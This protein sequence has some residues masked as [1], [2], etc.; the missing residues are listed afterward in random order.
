MK[1]KGK[2]PL[3]PTRQPGSGLSREGE[4]GEEKN[5]PG[6]ASGLPAG[7]PPLSDVDRKLLAQRDKALKPYAD[8]LPYDRD[9]VIT[10][11]KFLMRHEVIAK[12]EIGKRLI[13][14]REQEGVRTCGQ[15][16]EEHFPGMS[17]QR[18]YEY[19]LFARK[20]ANLPKV[21]DFAEGNGNWKKCLALLES[22][23]E[24]ELAALE[25]GESVAGKTLDDV[26]KMSFR[27]LKA[28]MRK[29]EE[30]I[31]KIKTDSA[32]TIFELE[33]K[34]RELEDENKSFKSGIKTPDD[35]WQQYKRADKQI[36][37]AAMIIKRLPEHIIVEDIVLRA[38][39]S[40]ALFVIET[41]VQN[42]IRN[43]AK[44][45]ESE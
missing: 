21:R 43:I 41:M 20:V 15:I 19:M 18:A 33:D 7:T 44:I 30:K 11:T 12:Y 2:S 26:D 45:D 1:D 22:F 14:L 32:M 27:E 38:K 13:L 6:P 23:D 40:G 24:E 29:G 42:I 37:D 9:R 10:E 35:Y 31:N 17:R 5:M 39:V 34:N 36:T 25:A 3:T 28:A 8:N 16:L 4:R